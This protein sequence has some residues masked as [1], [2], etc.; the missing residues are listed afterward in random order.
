MHLEGGVRKLNRIERDTLVILI[1]VA[2][3]FFVFTGQWQTLLSVLTGGI[4]MLGNF[5]FLWRFVRRIW[6]KQGAQRGGFLAGLFLLFFLFLGAVG[7]SLVYLKM[8]ILP[9]FAGTLCL[10][11]SIFLHGILFV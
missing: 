1:P 3:G 11:I 9:F 10:V 8:P 5:H 6:E 4:L 7:I 2:V